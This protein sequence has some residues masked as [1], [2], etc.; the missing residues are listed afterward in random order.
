MSRRLMR[1]SARV[2]LTIA[3]AGLAVSGCTPGPARQ[4]VLVLGLDGIDPDVVDLLV[5]EG[6][7]PNFAKLRREGAYGR[8]QSSRPLLSPIIWTT[9]ATG[10]PPE[11]HR[12]GHFV[13][14][15]EKTGA[16]PGD[17]PDARREGALEHPVGSR[18]ERGRGGLVGDLAGRDR[19]RRGR[20]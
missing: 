5:S 8:L 2:A 20:E 13:A 18:P 4:R 12:I 7:L 14:V 16:D 9:I 19:E 11:E 15:N 10:K 17:E 1:I 3:I 6:Q